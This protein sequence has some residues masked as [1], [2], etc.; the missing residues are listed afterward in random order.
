MS[1]RVLLA[2][3][4]LLAFATSAS[5]ECAWVLWEQLPQKIVAD[6]TDPARRWNPLES[7][8]SLR[9]CQ[10]EVDKYYAEISR[11]GQT[12]GSRPVCLPDT[13][14]PRGPKGR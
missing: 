2:A 12:P 14:D 3:L 4:G 8:T 10:A 1:A 11:A 7:Y 13:V 6:F 5:A 9:A